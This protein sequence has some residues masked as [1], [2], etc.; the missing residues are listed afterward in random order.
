MTTVPTTHRSTRTVRK[1]R[2]ASMT[3]TSSAV[4]MV[5]PTNPP[6][7]NQDQSPLLAVPPP[8]AGTAPIGATVAPA[9]SV[10][11]RVSSPLPL[12]SRTTIELTLAD[13][14]GTGASAVNEA[15]PDAVTV[16]GQ[17]PAATVE[18]AVA[19]AKGTS[20]ATVGPFLAWI[21][22]AGARLA[23]WMTRTRPLPAEAGWSSSCSTIPC[24]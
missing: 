15:P 19:V 22:P 18:Y 13:L 21:V 10:I 1:P 16:T 14:I 3:P 4:A 23:A 5:P 11:V 17:L 12:A 20:V 9:A 8:P 7:G 24:N 2:R 6:I